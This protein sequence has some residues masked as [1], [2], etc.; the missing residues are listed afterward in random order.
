MPF[1]KTL[2]FT[3]SIL[4]AFALPAQDISQ[5][6]DSLRQALQSHPAKD[7][8]RVWLLI[9]LINATFTSQPDEA[10]QYAEEAL[11]ISEKIKWQ[12]GIALSLKIK[13]GVYLVQSDYMKALDMYQRALKTDNGNSKKFE[14]GILNNIGNIH[15]NMRNLDKALEYYRKAFSVATALQDKHELS[16]AAGNLGTVFQRL[17]QYDS[18]LVYYRTSLVLTGETGNDRLKS[19]ALCFL[20]SLYHETKKFDSSIFYSLR[21]V[22]LADKTGNIYV[23]AAALHNLSNA[24]LAEGKLDSAEYY[25]KQSLLLAE[26]IGNLQSQYESWNSLREV[27]EKKGDYKKAYEAY[28]KYLT[29]RDSVY[30][31]EKRQELTRKE[32]Q[33]E[34]E[35]KELEMAAV[36]KQQQIIRNA[37]LTLAAVI[38][39]GSFASFIFY[40]RRKDAELR[41]KEAELKA[42]V[43][44]TQMK[45][46][47]AQMNPHFIFNSLNSIRHYNA[48]DNTMLA[49]EYLVRFSLLMRQVFENAEHKKVSIEDDLNALELY[50]QMETARLNDKFNYQVQV[51]NTIDREN[52]MIPPLLLQPFVENSI[53]HGISPKSGNGTIKIS[54]SRQSEMICCVVEDDGV[55]IKKDIVEKKE[56][57]EKK[58]RPSGIGI[59]RTRIDLMNRAQKVKAS[60]YIYPLNEGT[61]VEINL[62]LEFNF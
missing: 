57:E 38:L 37:A 40:K 32:V 2:L 15:V 41:Q 47:R 31:D 26:N 13:G 58:S 44:D 61:R 35:R 20:G 62:P 51:D 34:N 6:V 42:E 50:M 39:V 33:F 14:T 53:W 49:D 18:A 17:M 60:L 43:T 12:K 48:Q 19:N 27:Y 11:A 1:S 54:I 29:I 21:S 45:A 25:D 22:Q 36:I 7:S 8:N 16:M 24:F 55:G 5:P 56:K 10:M 23:K 3:F 28:N 59:T 30:N 4:F 52:T 46:L 9:H